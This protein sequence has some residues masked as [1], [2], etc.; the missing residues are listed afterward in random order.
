MEERERNIESYTKDYLSMPFLEENVK[1]RRDCVIEQ[2]MKYEHRNILEIGCGMFPL[3]EYLDVDYDHYLIIE[4]SQLFA[5]NAKNRSRNSGKIDVIEGC[6]EDVVSGF[7][8]KDFDFIVCSSLLHEVTDEEKFL[9]ALYET[10]NVNTTV[11]INV[12]NALS[13]HR[14]IAKEMGMIEDVYQQSGNQKILQ[15]RMVYDIQ[16]LK[17][18]VIE[19]GFQVMDEGSYF[20]KPFTH[21][22]MDRMMEEKIIDQTVLIG[23]QKIIKYF[24]NNGSEIFVNVRREI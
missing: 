3:F 5:Q 4:P 13:M 14:L 24:P 23:L 10:A 2:I 12:P 18:H 16:I 21:Y 9:K 17:E 11:H 1:Y 6:F 15:Q 20:I 7:T 19:N 22:Q 8:R